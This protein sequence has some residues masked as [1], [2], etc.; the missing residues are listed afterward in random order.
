MDS[1]RLLGS[2]IQFRLL[3]LRRNQ[4]SPEFEF[5]RLP[6]PRQYADYPAE[7]QNSL[8]PLRDQSLVFHQQC[9]KPLARL[10]T[11]APMIIDRIKHAAVTAIQCRRY[12][13]CNFLSLPTELARMGSSLRNRRNSSATSRAAAYRIDGDFSRFATRNLRPSRNFCDEP[14][15]R[16]ELQRVRRT[17]MLFSNGRLQL[18]FWRSSRI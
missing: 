15:V 1:R 13:R 6:T 7:I 9:T 12:Q 5:A 18:G 16:V 10:P 11:V 14:L 2:A 4:C 8:L 17:D 3:E